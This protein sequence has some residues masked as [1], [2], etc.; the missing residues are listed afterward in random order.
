[1]VPVEHEHSRLIPRFNGID[2]LFHKFIRLMHQVHIVFPR[3]ALSLVLHAAYDD[4][5][6]LQRLLCRIFP[7]S[8]HS[9]RKDKILPF[10]SV[11]GLHDI[12]H[13]NVVCGPSFRRCLKDVHKFLARIMVEAHVVKYLGA[14]VKVAAVIVERLCPVSEGSQCGRRA[15]QRLCLSVCLIRVLAR[16]EEAHAHPCEHLKLCIRCPRAHGWHLEV[17]RGILAEQLPQVR[18]R[19][20]GKAQ[21][22]HFRGV[23]K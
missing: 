21:P 16:P 13:K 12:R 1:M 15:L 4:L 9:D 17:P 5:R 2:Q 18:D 23:K 19:I 11:H 10:R 8:F 6:V 3:I 7:M 20:L 14:A 22:L